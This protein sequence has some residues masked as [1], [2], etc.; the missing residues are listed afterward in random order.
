MKLIHSLAALACV[1]LATAA[2]PAFAQHSDEPEAVLLVASPRLIDSDYRQTVVLAVPIDNDRH[3]GVIINRP[4]RRSLA[5]LFPEHQPSKKVLEP[6]FLGGPMSRAA[7][8]AVVRTAKDP[9]RGA[10]ELTKDM[11]LA[12]TVDVVDRIIEETPNDARYYVGY[13]VWRPGELR[14]EID[15]RVWSVANASPDIVFRKDTSGLW[16]ELSRL[17]RA[18]TA[19]IPPRQNRVS[20]DRSALSGTAP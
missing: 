18:V 6:V 15:R 11:Y 16:E 19:S 14:S 7:V 5:S 1:F 17:S 3:L 20:W 2:G 4:T 10:I 12:M 8:V 13:I 9:G